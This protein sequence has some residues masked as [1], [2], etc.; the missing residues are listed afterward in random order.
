M[1]RSF[2]DTLAHLPEA[3][4]S[5]EQ[6][7][8]RLIRD[9]ADLAYAVIECRL[10]QDRADLVNPAGFSIGRAYLHPQDNFPCVI[11]TS[12]G[13]PI[14]FINLLRWLGAGDG[15]S[16]SY[17]LDHKAQNKGYGKA[18]AKLA[19]QILK[20]AF[21][22][23]MIKLSTGAENKKAQALYASL[24]FQKLEE[25]DGDDLVFALV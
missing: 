25:R 17:Y 18:A 6:V 4:F 14:G 21:P 3:L 8:F 12:D 22:R 5:N 13:A 20:A 16:W 10:P 11:C 23:E 24:G 15:V 2:Y 19:V 7:R 9:E 1:S